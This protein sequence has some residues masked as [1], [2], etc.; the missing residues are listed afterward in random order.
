MLK[1]FVL[2]GMYLILSGT[3]EAVTLV[4]QPTFGA[5]TTAVVGRLAGKMNTD[6][7]NAGTAPTWNQDTT[8]T[9]SNLSGTP[10][11]PNGTSAT[12]QS[13]GD[14]STKLA[15]TAYI[16]GTMSES[17]WTPVLTF[18]TPGDVSVSYTQQ[19]GFY[20]Q[21][22]INGIKL[23]T[24][25]YR[26]NATPTYTT[27]SGSL[28]I[29]GLPA[30]SLSTANFYS[31]G[32]LEWSGINFGAGGQTNVISLVAPNVTRIQFQGSG[33]NVS[34]AAVSTTYVPSGA[35]VTLRGSFTYRAQ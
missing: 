14:N 19:S 10:A 31:T 12:T 4:G 25:H 28:Y 20:E 22:I 16:D 3:A 24:A 29:T 7:S 5:Y 17:T 34:P 15:T 6:Y 11:L 27:A 32:S 8:G 2:I 33:S 13:V 30:T 35:T 1:H 23:V 21:L 9:A 18:S 26:V